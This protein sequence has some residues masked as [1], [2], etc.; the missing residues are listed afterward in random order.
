MTKQNPLYIHPSMRE[1]MIN[2]SFSDLEPT[3]H[4]AHLNKI[5]NPDWPK[6][7][8]KNN[9]KQYGE[10]SSEKLMPYTPTKETWLITPLQNPK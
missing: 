4:Q 2:P 1:K 5:F 6:W 3:A 9:Q 8:M 10:E 7:A